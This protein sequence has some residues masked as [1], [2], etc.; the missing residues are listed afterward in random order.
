[1]KASIWWDAAQQW[2]QQ[3]L[4][5]FAGQQA[6][7]PPGRQPQSLGLG[8]LAVVILGIYNWGLLLAIAVGILSMVWVSRVQAQNW[9]WPSTVLRLLLQ[10]VSHRRL[11]LAAGGAATFSTYLATAVWQE[12][13]QPGIAI[14]VMGQGLGILGILLLLGGQR[15][16]QVQ[17]PEIPC[18]RRKVARKLRLL[19][20]LTSA[21]PLKRLLA[22]RQL[23]Q[24]FEQAQLSPMQTQILGESLRLMLRQEPQAIVRNAIL[25]ELQFLVDSGWLE[26]S[27]VPL[28]AQ[29]VSPLERQPRLTAN[30]SRQNR[31]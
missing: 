15:C 10:Q 4:V 29:A 23:G 1:M 28:P 31:R 14:G 24:R 11:T 27:P 13:H 9:Q 12:S 20:H 8:V 22:V 5:D 18:D 21:D 17:A 30:S 19:N 26:P 7:Y 25:D 3:A 2:G 16:S 6:A